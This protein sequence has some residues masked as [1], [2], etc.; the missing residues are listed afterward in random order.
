MRSRILFLGMQGL[1]S[2]PPFRALTKS[3]NTPLA[4]V[5]PPPPGRA[6]TFKKLSYP[7]PADA[8]KTPE[9]I[10]LCAVQN[11]V[12]IFE[13]GGLSDPETLAWLEK[14]NLDFIIVAC[15]NRLLPKTWL[16]TPRYGCINLHPSLLPAYRGPNPLVDQLKNGETSTGITL[17]FM[18]ESADTGDIIIQEQLPIPKNS[19][20]EALD[21]QAAAAGARLLLHI[22]ENPVTIPRR[23]QPR[24]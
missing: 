7:L 1:F 6:I 23:P 4:L 20:I 21:R 22:L 14:L 2:F 8:A 16:N 13:I 24:N 3:G 15:F 17:H 19:T 9:N 11:Q 10:Y 18:D 5:T 12:P